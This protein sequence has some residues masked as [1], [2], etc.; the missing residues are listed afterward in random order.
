MLK[1]LLECGDGWGNKEGFILGGRHIWS[2]WSQTWLNGIT[3]RPCLYIWIRNLTSDLPSEEV[4][5]SGCMLDWPRG[6]FRGP[7]ALALPQTNSIRIC[8]GEAG[9]A[10]F[11]KGSPGDYSKQPGLR[12]TGGD[13]LYF[14]VKPDSVS[15]LN[16][17]DWIVATYHYR[18][19]K[20]TPP[21]LL[22]QTAC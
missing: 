14:F 1:S 15:L 12:A 5:T 4:V 13:N 19:G 6:A 17:I 2:R 8:G 22:Q 21:S 7:S 11:I 10:G 16:I 3:W 18:R 9:A 20:L